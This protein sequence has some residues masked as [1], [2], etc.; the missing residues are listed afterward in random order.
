MPGGG[1]ESDG[2]G[3][4]GREIKETGEEFEKDERGQHRKERDR[5][6]DGDG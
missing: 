2:C 3:E 6:G 1:T 4:G 5:D